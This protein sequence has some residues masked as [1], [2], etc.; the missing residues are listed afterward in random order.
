M[1]K[2]TKKPRTSRI[3][4][5][6]GKQLKITL[7]AVTITVLLA[8]SAWFLL[9]SDAPTVEASWWPPAQI[10]GADAPLVRSRASGPEGTITR[11]LFYV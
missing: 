5:L 1:I 2:I 3:R 7:L 10:S 8:V 9:S 6:R 11:S 4:S